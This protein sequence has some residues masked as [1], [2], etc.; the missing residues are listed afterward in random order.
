MS[1]RFGCIWPQ[2]PPW[3]SLRY[4]GMDRRRLRMSGSVT[5]LWNGGGGGYRSWLVT[6]RGCRRTVCQLGHGSRAC[7]C[8]DADVGSRPP[9]KHLARYHSV[10]PPVPARTSTSRRLGS[11]ATPYRAVAR[12]PLKGSPRQLYRYKYP[13]QAL[14]NIRTFSHG[15]LP[16]PVTLPCTEL[17][18]VLGS[19]P[20]PQIRPRPIRLSSTSVPAL[21]RSS[22]R[23]SK[24]ADPPSAA[25]PFDF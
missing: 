11:T 15:M 18:P 2:V 6:A 10:R 7:C 5:C 19:V 24:C 22:A 13:Q 9:A 8:R 3:A 25:A 17:G 12:F 23:R 16:R 1:F 4:C 21:D 20:P 14:R